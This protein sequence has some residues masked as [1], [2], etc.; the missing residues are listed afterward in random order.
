MTD[1]ILPHDKD[2]EQLLLGACFCSDGLERVVD[3][4][5]PHDFYSEGGKIIFSKMVEFHRSGCGFTISLIER[6]FQDHPE[7][8]GILG[9]LDEIRPATAESA[10]HFAKIVKQ[11]SLRR[12]LIKATYDIHEILHDPS[13][14][15]EPFLRLLEG[16]QGGVNG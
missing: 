6:A 14:A 15:L 5:A 3:L 16:N 8:T 10:R 1:K 12:Q 11:L 7:Y 2:S 9:I 13:T 4:V